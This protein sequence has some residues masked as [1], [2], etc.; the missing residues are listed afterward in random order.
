MQAK[1]IKSAWQA[2]AYKIM[3]NT[4]SPFVMTLFEASSV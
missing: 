1:K 4:C 3:P 2:R